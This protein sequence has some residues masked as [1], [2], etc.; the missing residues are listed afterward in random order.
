MQDLGSIVQVGLVGLLVGSTQ[1]LRVISVLYSH[2]SP[3]L[4][5]ADL[6][7]STSKKPDTIPRCGEFA[8]RLLCG[9]Y[10]SK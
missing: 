9:T 4:Y 6:D 3:T 8:A 1:P 10:I 5:T 7:V 2:C